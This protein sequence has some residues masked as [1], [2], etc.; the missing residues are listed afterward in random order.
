MAEEI[1]RAL[2]ARRARPE[3]FAR[4]PDQQHEILDDERDAESREQLK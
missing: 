1:D 4:A 2:E 3:Q